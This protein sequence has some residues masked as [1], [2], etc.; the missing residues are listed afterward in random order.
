MNDWEGNRREI[1]FS[2]DYLAFRS[3]SS[4]S[5]LVLSDCAFDCMFF[6][7]DIMKFAFLDMGYFYIPINVHILWGSS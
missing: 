2:R 4:S 3:V 1:L 5:D 6:L 7:P